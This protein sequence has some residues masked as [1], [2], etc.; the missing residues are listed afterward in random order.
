VADYKKPSADIGS[1]DERGLKDGS[2]GGVSP[3]QQFAKRCHVSPRFYALTL[4][5][6]KRLVSEGKG[7]R[8][9]RRL[10]RLNRRIPVIG[11]AIGSPAPFQT[12]PNDVGRGLSLSQ[13]KVLG[14]YGLEI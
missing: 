9:N 3:L 8:N 11:L 5:P 12:H 14:F 10:Q 2:L 7:K 4:S 13:V 6:P 1:E